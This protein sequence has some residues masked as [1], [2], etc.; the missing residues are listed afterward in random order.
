MPSVYD[1]LYLH[2]AGNPHEKSL[3]CLAE[4]LGLTRCF[5]QSPFTLSGGEQVLLVILSKL[6]LAPNLLALDSTLG[7]LD[8]VN[9]ARI[10]QL[11]S[12]QLATNMTTVLTENGYVRDRPW[13]LPIR[14]SVSE[15]VKSS[16][17]PPRFF[18]SDFRFIP[19]ANIGSLE[20]EGVIFG[21]RPGS[22]VL[23]GVSLCLE[24]GRIYSLEGRNGA[25][26]STLARI[27]VGALSLRR[28]QIFFDHRPFKPWNQPGQVAVMHMQNPDIQLF[29]NSVYQELSDLPRFSMRPA[30]ALVGVENLMTEHPFDLPFVLRKRLTFSIIAHLRRPWFIFDEPTLGQDAR[31]CD[32]MVAI[33]R[34]MAKYGAGIIVISHSREFIRRLETQRLR[35]EDGLVSE[36]ETI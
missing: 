19:P 7:E 3:F 9:R 29:S 27:L 23:R 8:Q 34:Q 21:Y 33:L 5:H 2:A 20:A 1:E 24:P 12:S 11:F 30:A 18:A 25:G 36:L 15:F 26:K 16:V 28:G 22:L 4:S 17:K 31:A 35:L 14:R 6:G 13:N 10:T 32:Q